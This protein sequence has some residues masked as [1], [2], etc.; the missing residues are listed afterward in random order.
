MPREPVPHRYEE[1]PFLAPPCDLA[2]PYRQPF[3]DVA[4]VELLNAV[5]VDDVALHAVVLCHLM[6]SA[7]FIRT[8]KRDGRL[9]NGELVCIGPVVQQANQNGLLVLVGA[10]YLVRVLEESLGEGFLVRALDLDVYHL[11]LFTF[12]NVLAPVEDVDFLG[13][14]SGL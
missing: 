5:Q 1:E 13:A 4:E 10:P 3:I 14:L 9:G 8:G 7:V 11:R 2:L 12:V 6:L